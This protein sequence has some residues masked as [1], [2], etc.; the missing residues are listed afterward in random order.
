[1]ARLPIVGGDSGNWGTLLN[2][3]LQVAHNSDGTLNSVLS[4]YNVKD[5]GAEVD[6]ITNDTVAIQAAID[7]CAAARGGVVYIP[8]GITM[9]SGLTL[10]SFVW[11][12]G[13]GMRAMIVKLINGSNTHVIKNYV[14]SNGIEANA[15][16]C[17][18]L[19]LMIDGN[20]S[21]QT[22]GT[23][24]GIFFNTNPQFTQATNDIDFD[25][26]N[27]VQNVRIA[28][29]QNDGFNE[30]GRSETRLYNVISQNNN[31]N[32]FM[33]SFDSYLTMCSAGGSGLRGF[34]LTHSNI[35]LSACKAFGSGQITP[36]QG[37][38]FYIFNTQTIV[39]SACIA[40]NNNAQGLLLNEANSCDIQ[41][42]VDSN[43]NG[44]G[45]TQDQYAG[46]EVNNSKN[47][48][49]VAN[50]YQQNI[51]GYGNQGYALRVVNGSDQNDINI[52]NQ[53]QA[54]YTGLGD[55]SSD[56]VVLSNRIIVNGKNFSPLT[57]PPVITL[58]GAVTP[59]YTM[60][61]LESLLSCFGNITITLPDATKF[62]NAIYSIKKTDSANSIT[63]VPFTATP[64]QRID[65]HTSI[66]LNTFGQG[67]IFQ[68][69]GANWWI[70][71]QVATTIL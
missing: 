68:S 70:I 7:A 30:Q 65:S 44:I 2:Q 12:R 39:M 3:F 64:A 17:G 71:G 14:S 13:A 37:Q 41:C 5:Y 56:T 60:T 58:N 26:H 49:I 45:N 34:N 33:P 62:P 22:G 42:A 35:M 66:V 53:N 61:G 59:T 21:G 54:G 1:M 31:G 9:V 25:S 20:K 19:D 11:I 4:V 63:V 6:G 46:V 43:N 67:F 40:Q 57:A 29:C 28:N 16:Y 27:V 36:S 38:G 47:N 50:A 18:V 32:G 48:K 10:K 51:S 8:A 69:D 55:V 23:S 52:V 15:M 24:H